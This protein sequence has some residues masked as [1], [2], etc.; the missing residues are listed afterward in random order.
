MEPQLPV[1]VTKHSVETDSA[2]LAMTL[3][4]TVILG[5]SEK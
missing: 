5:G 1:T 2:G 4:Q 3:A